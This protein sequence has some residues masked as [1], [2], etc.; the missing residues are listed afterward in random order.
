VLV[1]QYGGKVQCALVSA[2]TGEGVQDLMEKVLLEAE[3]QELQANPKRAASGL[4][5]ESRLEKGR[6]N[7]STVLIQNGTLRVGDTFIAGIHSGRVRAMFDERENRIDEVG[8]A[9]PAL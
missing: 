2:H 6:G 9:R 7:V 4:I 8:P 5:I 1:E 3:L